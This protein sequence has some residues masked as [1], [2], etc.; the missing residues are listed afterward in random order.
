[1]G[2][3]QVTEMRGASLWGE[4][5]SAWQGYRVAGGPIVPLQGG[6]V[7]TGPLAFQDK[8]EIQNHVSNV[9]SLKVS[10]SLKYFRNPVEAGFGSQASIFFFFFGGGVSDES[11]SPRKEGP[12]ASVC[13]HREKQE[14]G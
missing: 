14:L 1:M 10:E 13:G 9:P 8:L 2:D 4:R 11:V 3:R 6:N 12:G 5:N 7:R